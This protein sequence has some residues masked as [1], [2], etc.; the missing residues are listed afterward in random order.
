MPLFDSLVKPAFDSVTGLIGEF[1]MSPEDKA[2][3][4][5][6]LADAEQRARQ[7]AADYDGKLNAIAGENIRAEMRCGDKFTERARPSFM[8]LVMAV[9]GFNYIAIPCCQIFGSKAQ[10]VYLPGELLTLFGVCITGYV[11]NRTVEKV[12]SLPGDSQISILG[13]RVGNKP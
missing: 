12:A 3:A 10:P 4:Q 2:K 13:M 8:Y 11:F 5:Q 6:A 9:L 7:T 1:H